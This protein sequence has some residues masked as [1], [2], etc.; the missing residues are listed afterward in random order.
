MKRSYNTDSL[1]RRQDLNSKS[2][3]R[4]N[5]IFN[6]DMDVKWYKQKEDENNL[7]ILPFIIQSKNN[8]L[9]RK[10]NRW[11]VGDT[12]Y[13]LEVYVHR[14]VGP[15][16]QSIICLNRNFG[17]PCPICEEAENLKEKGKDKEANFPSRRVI[18]NVL[19]ADNL[20]EGVMIFENSYSLFEDK[21]LFAERSKVKDGK[22]ICVAQVDNGYIIRCY[23]RKVKKGGYEYVEFLNFEFDERNEKQENAVKDNLD[24]VI[25]LDKYMNVLTYD[26]IQEILYGFEEDDVKETVKEEREKNDDREERR[27]RRREERENKKKNECP[28]GHKFG[29]DADNYR[30][31]NDCDIWEDCD[32]E[33]NK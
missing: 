15:G 17:K 24:N 4:G 20:K 11:K 9:L 3:R 5:S 30:D 7:I 19:D 16:N 14:F 18:Y 12:D 10:D 8:P 28:Y 1:L 2:G 27:R 21:L 25:D 6:F 29:V 13:V 32:E 22:H 31:C 26:E 33:N 23:G